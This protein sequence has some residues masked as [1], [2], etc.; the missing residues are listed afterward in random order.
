VARSASSSS[1][2]WPLII[3]SALLAAAGIF[4]L[5]RASRKN[6]ERKAEAPAV[7]TPGP[8]KTRTDKR[9]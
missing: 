3:V 8:A 5:D 9:K 4:L 7:V 6:R 1:V 2:P